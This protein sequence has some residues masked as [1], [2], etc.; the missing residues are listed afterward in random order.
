MNAWGFTSVELA[1]LEGD[2]TLTVDKLCERLNAF[3]R[4]RG[5]DPGRESDA[6]DASRDL[7]VDEATALGAFDWEI[8]G[9]TLRIWDSRYG[10]PSP[11]AE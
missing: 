3:A 10:K 9:D 2:D 4:E 7:I 6:L 5:I 1:T 8:V 11:W